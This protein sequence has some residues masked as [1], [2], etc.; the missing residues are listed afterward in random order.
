M[1][2]TSRM[3]ACGVLLSLSVVTYACEPTN[4]QEPERSCPPGQRGC[5][6]TPYGE[7]TPTSGDRLT[8]QQGWCVPQTCPAGAQG[9]AC[10]ANATCDPKDGV[11]MTCE[12]NLCRAT[13]AIP[14]GQLGGPCE[15]GAC[16]GSSASL[17]CDQGRCELAGC[18]SGEVGCGCGPY[19]QCS[20][21]SRC[22]G[23][24][25]V[26]SSCVV[27]APGCPCDDTPSCAPGYACDVGLCRRSTLALRFPDRAHACDVLLE[28]QQ[29]W[30][31]THALDASTKLARKSGSGRVA[32]S[33]IRTDAT[34]F[35][36]GAVTLTSQ[37]KPYIIRPDVRVVSATCYAR[38]GDPLPSTEVTLDE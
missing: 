24:L 14:A 19:G 32:L 15:E 22:L 27:G 5:P 33:M 29:S 34:P 28:D 38:D 23:G 16:D 9:C 30:I 17:M 37:E 4:V 31:D 6:C 10:H 13:V 26:A 1:N 3:F 25:C 35:A 12:G 8:C 20:P 11:P 21:G 2:L 18:P 36:A 7:C